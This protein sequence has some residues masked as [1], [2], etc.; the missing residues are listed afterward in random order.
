MLAVVFY[1]FVSSTLCV[2]L[3]ADCRGVWANSGHTRRRVAARGGAHVRQNEPALVVATAVGFSKERTT[4]CDKEFEG[5]G[6]VVWRE[7]K[8]FNQPM[9]QPI[10]HSVN[11]LIKQAINQSID[12]PILSVEA[13]VDIIC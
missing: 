4:L 8:L 3:R 9:C 1:T 6:V 2:P 12:Q 5:K 7:E 13:V 11:R 10:Y